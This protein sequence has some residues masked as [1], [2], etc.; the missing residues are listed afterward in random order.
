MIKLRTLRGEAILGNPG[1]P[2]VITRVLTCKQE[3]KAEGGARK[4][5]ATPENG[6]DMGT[7]EEGAT[8]QGKQG[9]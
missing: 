3:R 6:T 8:S 1:G 9:L 5:D 7:M 4:A 2:S